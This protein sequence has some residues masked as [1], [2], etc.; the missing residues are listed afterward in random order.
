MRRCGGT[1]RLRA[2]AGGVEGSIP[3]ALR[4]PVPQKF[5]ELISIVSFSITSAFG[6]LEGLCS[7]DRKR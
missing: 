5:Y 1:E 7:G 6:W 2:A 4:F 3:Q